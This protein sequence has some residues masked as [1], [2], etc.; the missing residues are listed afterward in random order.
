MERPPRRHL[1]ENITVLS[2]QPVCQLLISG[3][4]ASQSESSPP[5]AAMARAGRACAAA[6]RTGLCLT[7]G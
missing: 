6:A 2:R 7:D 4:G 1:E 3:G 5:V